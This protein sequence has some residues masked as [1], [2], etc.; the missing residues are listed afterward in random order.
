MRHGQRRLIWL[1]VGRLAVL[2]SLAVLGLF[3]LEAGA[4]RT[5]FMVVAAC[6]VASAAAAWFLLRGN[7]HL[8]WPYWII[9]GLDALLLGLLIHYAGGIEGPFVVFFYLHAAV[10]GLYLGLAGGAAMAA[11]DM[12]VLTT[13]GLVTL[14]GSPPEYTGGMLAFL[15]RSGML[16]L[17]T[18]YVLLKSFLDGLIMASIGLV[19]G[20]LSQHLTRETG[21]LQQLLRA[22]RETRERSMEVLESLED[23]VLVV[24]NDGELVS[25]NRSCREMLGL[26]KGGEG[27]G[28]RATRVYGLL[29][30]Y[31]EGGHFPENIDLVL[32]ERIVECRMG[33]F[34][35]EEGRNAGAMAVLTDVTELRD[36]RSRM[37]EREKLAVVGRLASTMAHE[38]RNP[39]ASMS[40]AAQ[41]LSGGSL[42]LAGAERMSRLIVDQAQRIS[43]TIESYLQLSRRSS[44]SSHEDLDPKPLIERVIEEGRTGT[45]ADIR[46]TRSL[47]EGLSLRGS[48]P[49]LMQ[50]MQNLLRNAAEATEG[51]E[52]RTIAVGLGYNPKKGSAEITV[53]DNGPGFPEGLDES[54]SRPFVTT[55]REGTGLGL[56]VARKVAEDHGGS[57][58]FD[59][60]T[61]GGALVK[62]SLPGCSCR[63]GR[64]AEE[65]ASDG[66]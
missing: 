49:R 43:E 7:P 41:V 11:L 10:A 45:L 9:S 63:Q 4:A 64:E 12:L 14:S 18:E 21:R 44:A 19:S 33:R 15:G 58:L 24:D 16:Q 1:Q 3:F 29:M 40:G 32:E 6:A 52:Q 39:L 26:E 61:L 42:D 59:A 51:Q 48:G 65:A 8:N 53:E 55:K 17:S 13:S 60:S 5:T 56:Y 37:E 36:L 22:L 66:G 34:V 30:D 50:M 25:I 38:I 54:I 23:G 2:G 57:I 62:V 46:I 20:Y 27:E 31:L 47:R 28:L 35:S